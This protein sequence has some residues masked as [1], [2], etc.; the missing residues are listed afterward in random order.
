MSKEKIK[1]IDE[2]K[3]ETIYDNIRVAAQ[4]VN[5]KMDE[6]KVQ[7]LIADAIVNKKRAFHAQWKKVEV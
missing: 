6:W 2:N 7:L 1:K 5:T 3:E 4:A